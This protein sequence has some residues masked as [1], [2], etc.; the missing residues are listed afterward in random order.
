MMH[1]PRLSALLLALSVADSPLSFVLAQSDDGQSAHMAARDSICV[2]DLRRHVG[3]LADD[4][5]EGREPGT[6]GGQQAGDYLLHHLR[7]V[8][9]SS[10][11][12]DE[13]SVQT[14]GEGYRNV[15]GVVAGSDSNLRREVVVVC[16]HY[17]HV[18]RGNEENSRG[19]WGQIHNGA[20][21][22]ASGVSAVLEIFDALCQLPTAPKRSVLFAFWDAE[23]KGS[24][25]CKYWIAH[26]TLS[27]NH[28]MSAV[29]LDMI[30][31]LRD[32]R[33]TVYGTRTAIGFRRLVS[34]NNLPARLSLDFSWDL[35]DDADHFPFVD[36]GVPVL[37]LHTGE[38][39][40]FHSPHDDADRINYEG[41]GR[42][43]QLAFD[44]VCAVAN[45]SDRP[46]FRQSAR[47]ETEEN[48]RQLE[49]RA[50]RLPDRLGAVWRSQGDL[51]G[52]VRVSG[53]LRGSP[54][55]QADI[56][57]NDRV[58]RIA[59]QDVHSP[60][61]LQSAVLLA[62]HEVQLSWR[63]PGGAALINRAVRLT[64]TP[65]R[66][67]VTWRRDEAEPNT[68]VLTHVV[69]GSAA[70]KAGL[71]AGDRIYRVGGQDLA[72]DDLLRQWAQSAAGAQSVLT[73]REGR[74][75]AVELRLDAAPET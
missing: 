45:Q 47:Q 30:G 40:E 19:P 49:M 43:T 22:N 14:F 65:L 23:E 72:D 13:L 71:R 33:L 68:V 55:E 15:L 2:E 12:D 56:R 39:D 69:A 64:G 38:H 62:Q 27:L 26:P 60:E 42:I 20:D 16:A 28:V 53:S 61:E 24:L 7:D 6:P 70:A 17:D 18:G 31:R 67:G 74:I 59:G 10:G 51:S 41:L 4:A 9:T 25:G 50:P 21:D 63:R 36:R 57:P 29:N 46:E 48:R 32:N 3:F 1:F 37:F 54:A 44:V 52:G 35:D 5:R 58:V 66:L 8:A 73:E 34:D 11:I 75:Q